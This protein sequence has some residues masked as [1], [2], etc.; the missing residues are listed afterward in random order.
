[1]LHQTVMNT[2]TPETNAALLLERDQLRKVC[3]ELAMQLDRIGFYIAG[4]ELNV[5]QSNKLATT[6]LGILKPYDSLPHVI[7][8]KK[9][10]EE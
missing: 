9:G 1:M 6:I 7:A 2:P 8:A 10:N 3:D 4:N 5:E